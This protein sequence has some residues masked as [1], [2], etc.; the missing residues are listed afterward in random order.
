MLIGAAARGMDQAGLLQQQ[1]DLQHVGHA[2]AHRDDALGDRIAAE[3][4]VRLGGGVEHGEFARGLLAVFHEG[5]GQR[6]RVAQFACQQRDPRLLVQ[7]QIGHAGHRRI[8]Q[9]GDRALVHGGILPDIEAGEMEAETIHGAAQ[10]PQPPARDHARIVRDQRAIENIEIGL[11]LRRHRHRAQP[12]RPARAGNADIQLQRGRGQPRVNAR[13]REAIGLAAAMRRLVGRAF[14]EIAQ[15]LGDVGEMRGQ[16]QLG[17]EHVQFLEIEA[18]HPA[19]LQ[20]RACRASPLRSRT[21]CRRDRR[22]SSFPSSGTTPVRRARRC[23][24]RSAGPPARNAAAAPRAGRCS[25]RTT[26]RWRLRRAR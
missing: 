15:I 19:R 14:G 20:L 25:R 11:E 10:Q 2:L 24:P 17:A 26:G 1:R 4:G 9:F 13:Y 8:D 22:R 5:G 12:R 16:R 7:R 3:L 6:T 23:R 18:Q 21:G